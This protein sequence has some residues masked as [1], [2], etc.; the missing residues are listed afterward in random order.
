MFCHGL[1]VIVFQVVEGIELRCQVLE[2]AT[3]GLEVRSLGVA[4]VLFFAAFEL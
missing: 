2:A 3:V 4:D 1:I